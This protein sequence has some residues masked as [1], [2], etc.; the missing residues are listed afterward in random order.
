MIQYCEMCGCM[1]RDRPPGSKCGDLSWS[2]HLIEQ[3]WPC[4]GTLLSEKAVEICRTTGAIE[5]D[6]PT[7]REW[8]RRS[9]AREWQRR[10]LL[11]IEHGDRELFQELQRQKLAWIYGIIKP[12]PNWKE[13]GGMVK[14]FNLGTDESTKIVLMTDCESEDDF[15]RQLA[16]ALLTLDYADDNVVY[17][18]QM[19][20]RAFDIVA[21]YR[22]YKNGAKAR[23]TL[24]AG[25]VWPP[26]DLAPIAVGGERDFQTVEDES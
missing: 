22:G 3:A 13:G 1:Y 17:F 24:L 25:D 2:R 20:E 5:S 4:P 23:T 26:D 9:T 18:E 8:Q 14:I 6:H 11:A 16:R 12:E 21:K 7:A 19:L 15:R 10:L